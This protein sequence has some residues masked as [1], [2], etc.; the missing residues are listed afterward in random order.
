MATHKEVVDGQV[1]ASV[2]GA[3]ALRGLQPGA[4]VVWRR[5][6]GDLATTL[7]RGP[8][9]GPNGTMLVTLAGSGCCGVPCD[10]VVA[11]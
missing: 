11:G 5:K 4:A 3:E 6:G 1:A 2:A 8:W 7:Q 10:K 9:A